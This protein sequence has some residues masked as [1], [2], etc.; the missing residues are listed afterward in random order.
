MLQ[1]A[2]LSRSPA[3]RT[4]WLPITYMA[5]APPAAAMF[6]MLSKVGVYVVLRVSSLAFGPAA[7]HMA[8]VE[9]PGGKYK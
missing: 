7:T 4:F 1:I 5:A 2:S 3:G 9:H 6:A 8:G